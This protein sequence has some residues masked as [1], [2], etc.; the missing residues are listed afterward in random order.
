MNDQKM[1]RR[2]NVIWIITDQHR[3]QSLGV[4]GD[5]NVC[6]PNIDRLAG[7][8]I[9]VVRAYTEFP[10]C[11]PARGTLLTGKFAHGVIPGHEYPMPDGQRTVADTF[12]ETGYETAWF[13]KWHLDGFHESEGRAAFHTVPK[14]R[15]GGFRTWLGYDNNNSQ[16]DSYVH[17]HLA[18]GTEVPHEKLPGYETDALTDR[19]IDFVTA[20]K[21]DYPFFAVLS[22]QPP[23]NPYLAPEEWMQRHNPASVELRPNVPPVER[24]EKRARRELAGYSAMIEN[25]DW[26]VGRLREALEEAGFWDD[27]YIVFFS[28][29]G[30]MH[31]SH[32]QFL[33]TSPWEES[34]NIPLIFGGG[35]PFYDHKQ[36]DVPHLVGLRDLAPTTLGLCGIPVPEEMEGIDFSGLLLKEKPAPDRPESLFMYSIV[37]TGHPDSVNLP[38]RS[39]ITDDGWKLVCFERT[40]WLMFNLNEDPYEMVNLAHNNIY[41]AERERLMKLLGQWIAD[42]QDEFKL[43]EG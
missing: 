41:A 3:A 16:W 7:E 24:V 8:G 33:K 29:H 35:V 30:D 26:N 5:P 11:C 10:L 20:R 4:H 2:P 19:M 23:H 39:V 28:D 6:T 9:D 42:A 27:T 22:V 32:G 14:A 40:S 36:G 25:F 15:R 38:W 34:V 1:K 37:P 17:G 43:G 31:G 18:D 12:E 21:D 13:G